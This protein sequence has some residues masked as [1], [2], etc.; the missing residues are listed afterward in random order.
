VT[1]VKIL[2]A[3]QATTPAAAQRAFGIFKKPVTY[4]SETVCGRFKSFLYLRKQVLYCTS[5][6]MSSNHT[7]RSS[8]KISDFQSFAKASRERVPA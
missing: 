2:N 8:T 6:A 5:E 7:S 4:P 1:L 3:H